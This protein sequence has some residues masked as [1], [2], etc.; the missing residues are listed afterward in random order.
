MTIVERSNCIMGIKDTVEIKTHQNPEIEPTPQSVGTV[1]PVRL[2]DD[3][4]VVCSIGIMAHNEEANISHTIHALLRQ[5]GS[6]MCIEEIIV[7][8]SGCTDC[9]VAIVREI[10][11]KEPRVRLCTQ[12]KR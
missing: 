6:S 8:A 2:Q 12:E 7:V 3:E 10:A 4:Y 1:A 9:T 5:Q 11:L